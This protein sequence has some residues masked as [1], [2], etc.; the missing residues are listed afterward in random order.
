MKNK[1]KLIML[2]A[3]T[4]AFTG[5]SEDFLET[6]PTEFASADQ[7]KDA[8]ELSPSLQNANVAGLYTTMIVSGS[9]GTTGHDDFGQ[10]GNDIFVDMLTGDMVLAG[11]TYGWYQDIVEYQSTVDF[12]DQNNYQMWR[13]YYRLIFGANNIIDGLGGNDAVLENDEA[14][15][16]MGQAKAMRAYSYFYLAQYYSNGYNPSE[17]ILPVYTDVEGIAKGLSP[18][19]EVYALIIS[20]LTESISLLDTFTRPA[21]N[22]I[23]KDVAKGLLAYTY[24]AM[25][26]YAE[27]KT[28]TDE[29]ITSGTYQIVPRGEVAYTGDPSIGG[30]KNLNTSGW[31]WGSDITLDNGLDLV[32]WWGQIDLFTYSYAW[33]GDPKT[34][35]AEL[36]DAIPATD[37]RKSQFVDAYGD[38]V[39]YP[40]NKF[41][42]DVRAVAGQRNIT[43]DYVYMRI[44]EMYLLNAEAA[45]M[46]GD[47]AAA[48]QSLKALL[49]ERVDD[50]SYVDGLS[51]Q[52]LIDEIYL[53]TRIEFWG[54]GK[55]YLAVKRLKKTVT[56]GSNH[57]SLPGTSYS[58][59]SS[60]LTFE[61]PLSEVQN[62]PN[63]N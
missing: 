10:K 36:Y 37:V 58:Y 53:Q 45:A 63:I 34:I 5:C 26:N 35:H 41:Y 50:V 55:S 25:G 27:V 38:G 59:D 13:Y 8:S 12:T 40:I 61:I 42:P 1:F 51:G 15:Y 60:E 6:E 11:Y 33:A 4:I 57:L 2:F 29:L 23:N 14:K 9:G 20:D 18:A 43:T 47:V 62:N 28:L 44:A 3:G 17:A 21:K 7:I 19:S 52:A 48:G 16:I 39:L 49:S 32:S 31:M 54:E 22:A 24:A 30:F 46:T 56:T